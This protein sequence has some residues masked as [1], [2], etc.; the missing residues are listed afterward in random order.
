MNRAKL[1]LPAALSPCRFIVAPSLS[2]SRARTIKLSDRWLLSSQAFQE[3]R[4]APGE[5]GALS[6]RAADTC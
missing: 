3:L 6:K 1:L 2:N 5:E 4:K